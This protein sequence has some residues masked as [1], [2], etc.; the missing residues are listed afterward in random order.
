MISSVYRFDNSAKKPR[1]K[2]DPTLKKYGLFF[3]DF[4]MKSPNKSASDFRAN[5]KKRV[6]F[7]NINSKNLNILNV[8]H[9]Q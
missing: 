1:L 9:L 8:F 3:P 5:S 7:F 4:K 6:S 2:K